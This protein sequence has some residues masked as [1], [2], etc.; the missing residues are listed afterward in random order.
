MRR[1]EFMAL[2]PLD[3]FMLHMGKDIL[4]RG[5][6]ITRSSDAITADVID[7]GESGEGLA[8]FFA[9]MTSEGAARI[10]IGE[11]LTDV[12]LEVDYD[13]ET[14]A[15]ANRPTVEEALDML[16]DKY[17]LVVVLRDIE[18]LSHSETIHALDLQDDTIRNYLFKGRKRLREILGSWEA[19]D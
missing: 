13:A 10:Y 7:L 9:R 8:F 6:V 16:E 11:V 4:L 3:T 1:R 18:K 12:R 5:V 15:Q 14:T 2:K 19:N 17:R